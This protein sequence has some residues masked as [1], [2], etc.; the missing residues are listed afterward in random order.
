MNLEVS[1]CLPQEALTVTLV[2]AVVA[3]ALRTF[4][5]AAACIEDIRL[6]LSE[7]C[8]NVIDHATAHDAYEVQVRVDDQRCGISI[9]NT[10]EGFDAAGLVG[11]MPDTSSPRGRGVA[12]MRAV[13]DG[14][15]LRSEP[16]GG[17][18]VHLVKRLQFTRDA[19]IL[20]LFEDQAPPANR[21][22]RG[23]R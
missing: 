7:A 13:M 21:E 18:V 9:V 14:V 11:A 3:D 19:P 4:G 16:T 20:H 8:T 22:A 2:R 6:A 17:T 5:V 10:G 23:G 15:E 1:V 12:I